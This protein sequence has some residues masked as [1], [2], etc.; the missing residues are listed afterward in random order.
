MT[1][2]TIGRQL[3]ERG[4]WLSAYLFFDGTVHSEAAD[5]IIRDVVAPFTARQL[6]MGRLGRWYF[7]RYSH[8]G[9]HVRVRMLPT[10]EEAGSSI[11][12]EFETECESSRR[13]TEVEWA[14]YAPEIAR[15]G[16]Q[17]AMPLAEQIFED[18]SKLACDVLATHRTFQDRACRCGVALLSMLVLMRAFSAVNARDSIDDSIAEF[19]AYYSDGYRQLIAGSEAAQME[20]LSEFERASEQDRDRVAPYVDDAIDRLARGAGLTAALDAYNH[21]IVQR[22]LAFIDLFEAGR[23]VARTNSQ[24]GV[25]QAIFAIVPSYM[26]MTNNRLG[27]SIDEE[28]YLAFLL[29]AIFSSRNSVRP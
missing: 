24:Q 25:R 20:M 9:P 5:G 15:Y 10:N 12:R 4:S 27:V 2:R 7:V 6:A 22:C 19:A 21:A 23:I 3:I 8:N 1:M 28:A 13:V 16:G 14:K 17:A 11:I 18:S 29:S 26:H